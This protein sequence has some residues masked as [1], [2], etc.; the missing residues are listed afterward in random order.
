VSRDR[1]RLFL[2]EGVP[3]AV[4]RVF[5]EAGHTVIYLRDSIPT[6]SPDELVAVA[7]ERND[8]IL[9]ACDG[10]MRQLVKRFGIGDGRF[11]K[12][13]L[14]KISCPEPQAAARVESA[15]SLIEHEW[16][17]SAGKVARRLFVELSK[18]S[19]RTYR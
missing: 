5:T 12:L 16:R 9:V 3:D 1:L 15:M 7:A 8:A 19:I 17:V 18:N 11:R 2:D 4:G 6:G 14:I 10:D 13:S